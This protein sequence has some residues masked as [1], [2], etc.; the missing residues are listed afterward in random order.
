MGQLSPDNQRDIP[1]HM[2]ALSAC[3]EKKKEC[4]DIL[5]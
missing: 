2:S 1:Y 3:R 4:G 5:E